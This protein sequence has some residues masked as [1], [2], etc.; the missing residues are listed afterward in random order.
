[1]VLTLGVVAL[2]VLGV[3]AAFNNWQEKANRDPCAGNLKSIGQ[4][5]FLYSEEHEGK[6]PASLEELITDPSLN[7][8]TAL[9]ICPNTP[10]QTRF[11]YKPRCAAGDADFAGAAR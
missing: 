10:R 5:M 7:M 2:L 11:R 3:R 9:L 4:G 1:L 6:F 8:S